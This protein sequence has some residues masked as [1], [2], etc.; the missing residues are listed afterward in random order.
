MNKHKIDSTDCVHAGVGVCDV[1]NAI[2]IPIVHS[3]PFTFGS[4]AELVAYLEGSSERRQPEY[5]RMGNPTVSLV[6]S[7]LA[8]LEGAEKAQL[9]ASGMAAVTTLFLH[10]LTSGDHLILINDCYKRTRDFALN[11]LS[12]FGIRTSVVPPLL[13]EV[14]KAVEPD[15][16]MIFTETPTNPYLY[17]M[18]V[19]AISRIGRECGALSVVDSTF[20]TPVNL[21]PLELGADLVMHSAT[22]YMGGHNDLIA[23]VIA[24]RKELVQPV[25]DLLMT[26]GG[27]CDPQSVYLLDRGLKT[28]KLRVTH[29]NASA[30]AI[31]E[32]LKSHPKVRRVFYPGLKCHPSHEIASR[33]MA[34]YG[35][36][37][38]FFLDGEF[39]ETARFVDNLQI[40]KIGPS[41]G[42][43]ESLVEQPV[44]M[45]YWDQPVQERLKWNIHDNMVRLSI[46]IEETED[47]ITDLEQALEKI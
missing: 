42:G 34:G 11:F 24:G 22:K 15:T 17:V 31:A 44:I 10:Y 1:S 37:V 30:L 6:E 36:V 46:G 16:R 20:A 8:A 4:T 14:K 45:S 23:G 12:K 28:L 47:I 26:L 27:I 19:D 32:F 7:R 25:S 2:T 39:E 29:Q 33:Q 18:D 3:A 13:K 43:V 41:L 5:G 40:P 9:F 35:G 21:R 38:T